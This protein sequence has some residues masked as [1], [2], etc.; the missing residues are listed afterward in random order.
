MKNKVFVFSLLSFGILSSCNQNAEPEENTDQEIEVEVVEEK[1]VDHPE[2]YEIDGLKIYPSSPSAQFPE[3]S[4]GFAEEMKS[5]SED[6][7]FN[8][9]FSVSGYELG[10]QSPDA[11]TKGLANSAKGQHIH[12]IVDNGPYSAHYESGFEKSFEK[13]HHIAIAF[14]SRSYHESVKGA[15]AHQVFQFTSGSEEDAADVDLSQEMLF[16]SR[17]KGSYTG[18][19]A[20]KILVDFFLKNTEIAP[21]GNYIKMTINGSTSVLLDNWQPY[22]IEGLPM[23]ENTIKLQL[24]NS[25]GNLVDSPMNDITRTFTL[26]EEAAE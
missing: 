23:G 8:F 25:E 24:L 11:E 16:Y 5:I 3:A 12:L 10:A 4:L 7:N 15:N 20:E 2:S 13:G 17:P 22:F 21:G 18:K 14:L 9:N 6:G 19:G 26:A 1:I